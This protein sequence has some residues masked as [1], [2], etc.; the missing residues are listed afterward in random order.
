MPVAG[1]PQTMPGGQRIGVFP[2]TGIGTSS[3]PDGQQPFVLFAPM[4]SGTA[5]GRFTLLQQERGQRTA[6]ADH[7]LHVPLS[8]R[9]VEFVIR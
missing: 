9:R 5:A 7:G 6:R 1:G 3:A 4:A 8:A 2:L